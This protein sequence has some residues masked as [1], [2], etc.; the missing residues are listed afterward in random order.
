MEYVEMNKR[1]KEGSEQYVW[2]ASFSGYGH[3]E[4]PI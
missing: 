1:M 4:G 3:F 2:L